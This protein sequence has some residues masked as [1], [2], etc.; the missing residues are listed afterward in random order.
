MNVLSFINCFNKL[1]PQFH[2]YQVFN[3]FVQLTFIAMHNAVPQ[4][5]LEI[6]EAEAI[7]IKAKYSEKEQEGFAELFVILVQ[8]LEPKPYDVLGDV[9]MA[10]GLGNA[11]AGQFFTPDSIN[12]LTR[13]IV[14]DTITNE[15]YVML[16]EP[17]CGS[18]GLILAYV[19]KFIK[20]GHVP[21]FKLFVEAKDL[22]RT[23]AMMCY[24]QLALWGVPAR[25][26]VGDTLAGNVVECW[27]TSAYVYH[28]WGS[29][30][31]ER[32]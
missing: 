30:L 12:K 7:S 14:G 27:Y 19:A 4:L 18:G 16:S 32:K 10:L 21:A 26:I 25:V 15:P 3:D 20:A 28:R 8:L 11:K 23:A 9:Y 22:D 5:R 17:S 1:A 6:L 13:D 2:R 24:I 31:K 29:K